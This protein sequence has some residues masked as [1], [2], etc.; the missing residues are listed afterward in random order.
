MKKFYHKEDITI[1]WDPTLC[2]HSGICARG[3]P[4]VFRP[5]ERP[6]VTTEHAGKEDIIKQVRKCPSGALTLINHGKQE[7]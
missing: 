4:S 6:W 3:L 7:R 5:G 2:I 1:Q